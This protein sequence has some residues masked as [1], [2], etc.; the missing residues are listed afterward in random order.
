MSLFNSISTKMTNAGVSAVR[1]NVNSAASSIAREVNGGINSATGSAR[2]DLNR[3]VSDVLGSTAGGI[4]NSAL[5]A[6]IYSGL[7][8]ARGAISGLEMGQAF[9]TGGQNLRVGNTG[10]S[11][12][13]SCGASPVLGGVRMAEAMDLHQE[14]IEA[15]YAKKNLFMLEVVSSPLMGNFSHHFNLYA[16]NVEYTP[17][18]ISGDKIK[19]GSAVLDSVLSAE[20]I[21][22]R[23][24]T[25][26]DKFGTVRKWFDAH[27]AASAGSDGTVGYP[28]DYLIRIKVTHAFITPDSNEGGHEDFGLYR[29]SNVDVSLSRSEDALEEMTMTFVQLD[30]FMSP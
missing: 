10:G 16:F 6:G 18:T 30:T 2:S 27:A 14:Q 5:N 4:A 19:V 15:G 24:T 13:Q 12:S 22:M 3:A 7:N 26:D 23:V 17:V 29:A 11:Q 1:Q 28:A 9:G 8:A 25:R 21:E 20:A